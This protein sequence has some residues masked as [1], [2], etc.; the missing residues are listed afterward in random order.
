MKKHLL[1]LNLNG[2]NADAQ[3]KILPL[4]QGEHELAMLRELIASE[5]DGPVGILDHQADLDAK[6][7]LQDNLDGLEWLMKEIERPGSAGPRPVPK[8]R[9]HLE[10][11]SR[12]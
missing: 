12:N 11:S 3:P 7:A 10:S 5:Y 2:M 6:E 9:P 8:A 4:G 1:C